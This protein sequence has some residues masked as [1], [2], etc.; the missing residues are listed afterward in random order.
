MEGTN[1]EQDAALEAQASVV[2]DQLMPLK[3]M[4]LTSEHIREMYAEDGSCSQI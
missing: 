1:A 3:Q 4:D 2:V